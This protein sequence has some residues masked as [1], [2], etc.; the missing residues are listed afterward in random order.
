[1]MQSCSL[2]SPLMHISNAFK[3][4]Y[5]E[6]ETELLNSLKVYDV[7]QSIHSVQDDDD[8]VTSGGDFYHHTQSSPLVDCEDRPLNLTCKK[9]KVKDMLEIPPSPNS[10]RNQIEMFQPWKDTA[11]AES[12]H[13]P[14]TSS[15][16]VER[17]ML[18][19][20]AQIFASVLQRRWNQEMAC[21]MQQM[22]AMP[23]SKCLNSADG[24]W[25]PMVKHFESVPQGF[26]IN[27]Y[28]T[29][30]NR[31]KM[32][33]ERDCTKSSFVEAFTSPS[34]ISASPTS[35]PPISPSVE[36][37]FTPQSSPLFLTPARKS[38]SPPSTE[39]I[40]PMYFEKQFLSL[41]KQNEEKPLDVTELL[42]EKEY[43][44]SPC[45]SSL[46]S[47]M[48]KRRRRCKRPNEKTSNS[49]TNVESFPCSLCKAS[50][51]HKFE[52]N[53]HVKVS[54]VRPHR[55]NQC[56]KGFG[57]RNYLKVHIE[58]VHMGR[59]SHQCRLCG[60]YLSTGGNL[61][62]HVRTI[63]LGEKK[64]NCPVCNRSFGQQCNMKT[65]M[66]RHYAKSDDL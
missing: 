4:S 39:K 61:N 20:R 43:I 5:V 65:H 13:L 29:F 63:H 22:Q 7:F 46:S 6:R 18:Q 32:S 58:T 24:Q 45:L 42:P 25:L 11:P 21:A 14:I 16:A 51:P 50:Y 9:R 19:Y 36:K 38:L 37:T 23:V 26:A 48:S 1:M 60:K 15:E 30:R 12:N 57:H 59:K 53:R 55:C 3:P 17:A 62:V 28:E 44:A 40:S 8:S 52:L 33:C 27:S 47:D 64:F 49:S 66:K 35:S 56:G 54:H 41:T 34:S 31:A 2:P 10:R